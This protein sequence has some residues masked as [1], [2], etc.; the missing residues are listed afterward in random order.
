M[1]E[2][3]QIRTLGWETQWRAARVGQKWSELSGETRLEVISNKT[4]VSLQPT[5]FP[6]GQ[7]WEEN[8]LVLSI[9]M[10]PFFCKWPIRSIRLVCLFG[11][12]I[13][14]KFALSSLVVL[15]SCFCM[16]SLDPQTKYKYLQRW[17]L[18]AR[19]SHPLDCRPPRSDVKPF[20]GRCCPWLCSWLI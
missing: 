20:R 13:L 17:L 14:E 16:N 15:N 12:S 2:W 11:G 8:V 3:T 4:S 9:L 1:M 6:A 18:Q 5:T 10:I 7:C 19:G